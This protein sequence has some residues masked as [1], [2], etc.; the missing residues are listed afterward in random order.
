MVGDWPDRDVVGAKTCGMTTCWAK[1]GSRFDIGKA[2]FV[3]EKVK[4]IVK[5]VKTLS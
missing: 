4:D 5:V 3:L 2:D 1:Y